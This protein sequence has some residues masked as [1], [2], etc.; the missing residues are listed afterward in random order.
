MEQ[1]LCK[2]PTVPLS[3]QQAIAHKYNSNP[4]G[5]KNNASIFSFSYLK[6]QLQLNKG[7]HL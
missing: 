2:R 3:Y 4:D 5:R 6:F 1:S 7:K